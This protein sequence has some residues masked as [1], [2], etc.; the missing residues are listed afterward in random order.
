MS[1]EGLIAGALSLRGCDAVEFLHVALVG[2][3]IRGPREHHET[4][5][6]SRQRHVGFDVSHVAI[7]ATNNATHVGTQYEREIPRD[8]H[9]AKTFGAAAGS[10]S[11][12]PC[13]CA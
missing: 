12:N 10:M 7:I 11:P 1:A 3:S 8:G 6:T 4:A 9:S 5:R 13:R 2:E